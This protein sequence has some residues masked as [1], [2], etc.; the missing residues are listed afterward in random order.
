MTNIYTQPSQF[1]GGGLLNNLT[2]YLHWGK[3][4]ATSVLDMILNYL[5]VRL[6]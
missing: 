6:Q 4:P 3:T 5:M 2:A 1:Q